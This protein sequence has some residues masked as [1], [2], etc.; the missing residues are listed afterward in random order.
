MAGVTAVVGAKKSR[1]TEPPRD[2]SKH[3]VFACSACHVVITG[4]GVLWDGD[5][6]LDDGEPAL[7][8]GFFACSNDD[9]WKGTD[10]DVLVNLKDLV[11]TASHPDYRR[12]TGCCGC[13][14]CDGPNRVCP[15][16]HEVATEHSDCWMAQ[17]P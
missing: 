1:M 7:P 15:N 4:P 6:C 13:D 10:G 11:E 14:D 9:Y 3:V 16:G 12:S 17:R 5:L 8:P 2:V